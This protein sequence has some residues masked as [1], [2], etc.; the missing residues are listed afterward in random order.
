MQVHG[1]GRET[2]PNN[3]THHQHG[4]CEW[5]VP[6]ALWNSE[7]VETWGIVHRRVFGHLQVFVNILGYLLY[8]WYW[9]WMCKHTDCLVIKVTLINHW[10]TINES[11]WVKPHGLSRFLLWWE[12][13][14]STFLPLA[15]IQTLNAAVFIQFFP[16]TNLLEFWIP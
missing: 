16:E 8:C 10:P 5:W 3:E 4:V 14:N 9:S 1:E 11:L 2:W 6:V 13:A 15:K 12:L 7:G